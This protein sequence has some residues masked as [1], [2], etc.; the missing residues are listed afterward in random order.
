VSVRLVAPDGD[1]LAQR[2]SWPADGLLPTSQW[3]QRDYV[4]DEHT[5]QLPAN[6]LPGDHAVQVQVVVYDAESDVVLSGPVEVESF[7]FSAAD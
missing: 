4:R 3:R 1:R 6:L 2:D 5:L 7:I